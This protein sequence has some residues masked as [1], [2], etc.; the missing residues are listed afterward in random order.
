MPL[1]NKS[2]FLFPSHVYS[3]GLVPLGWVPFTQKLM[4]MEPLLSAMFFSIA[5]GKK[6][7]EYL[8]SAFK[9]HDGSGISLPLQFIG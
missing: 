3:G 1:N 9:C 2:L 8:A 7:P 5:D 4:E 6:A